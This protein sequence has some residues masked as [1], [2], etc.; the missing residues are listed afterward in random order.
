MWFCA[1]SRRF[2]L[3]KDEIFSGLVISDGS[4]GGGVGIIVTLPKSVASKCWR[5][6]VTLEQELSSGHVEYGVELSFSA[7]IVSTSSWEFGCQSSNSLECPPWIAPAGASPPLFS[8][9][10][11]CDSL[12]RCNKK[13]WTINVETRNESAPSFEAGKSYRACCINV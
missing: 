9:L 11:L 3:S 7:W 12:P 6:E 8:D 10:C 13:F 1:L 5:G 2:V 4:N